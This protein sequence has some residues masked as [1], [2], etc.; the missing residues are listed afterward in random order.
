MITVCLESKTTPKQASLEHQGVGLLDDGW[1]MIS[2]LCGLPGD[3]YG[4]IGPEIVDIARRKT[5]QAIE[6]KDYMA[7]LELDTGYA[8]GRF[9]RL[10][11]LMDEAAKQGVGLIIKKGFHNTVQDGV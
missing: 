8:S 6:S 5:K 11:G 3:L 7:I 2:S 9:Y 4:Y 10:L 1:P